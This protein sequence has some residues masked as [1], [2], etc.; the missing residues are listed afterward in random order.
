MCQ[1]HTKLMASVVEPLLILQIRTWFFFNGTFCGVLELG[2][3]VAIED[4]HIMRLR[5]T[6]N[7]KINSL[8]K[9]KMGVCC[10]KTLQLASVPNKAVQECIPSWFCYAD[11]AA[12]LPGDQIKS[13]CLT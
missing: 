5:T 12:L 13:T 10:F 7:I 9:L 11:K 4:K 2:E 3:N 1:S 8:M 6:E